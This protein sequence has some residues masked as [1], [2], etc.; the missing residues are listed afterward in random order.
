[1]KGSRCNAVAVSGISSYSKIVSD[2]NA[3]DMLYNKRGDFMNK[4]RS[5]APNGAAEERNTD[6][7]L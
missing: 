6:M 2:P 4:W 1:M 5:L 7:L 3:Y